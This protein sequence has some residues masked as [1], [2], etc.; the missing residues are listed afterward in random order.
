M[1][2]NYNSLND[3]VASFS[4]SEFIVTIGTPRDDIEELK[5]LIASSFATNP[6]RKE[7]GITKELLKDEVQGVAEKALNER[8]SILIRERKSGKLASFMINEDFATQ[9]KSNK[10]S[11]IPE[12]KRRCVDAITNVDS[13]AIQILGFEPENLSKGDLFFVHLGGT[14]NGFEGFGLSTLTVVASIELGKRLGYKHFVSTSTNIVSYRILLKL[15]FHSVVRKNFL[16]FEFPPGSNQFPLK[17]IPSK[18]AS[19]EAHVL[20]QSFVSRL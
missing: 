4:T 9:F 6:V 10:K 19:K 12:E 3:L 15:G 2:P 18:G 13:K 20:I 8:I 5:E 7:L 14:Q 1:S 16:E 11:P 17:E